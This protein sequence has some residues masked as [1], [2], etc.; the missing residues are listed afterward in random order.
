MFEPILHLL[1]GVLKTRIQKRPDTFITAHILLL[2]FISQLTVVKY[3]GENSMHRLVALKTIAELVWGKKSFCATDYM[4]H[5]A[6][7]W[8]GEG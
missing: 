7:V 5:T 4:Q 8:A 2:C 1:R 6:S 3:L